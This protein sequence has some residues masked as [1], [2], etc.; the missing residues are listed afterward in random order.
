MATAAPCPYR[1]TTSRL[2]IAGDIEQATA[3][4]SRAHTR[5]LNNGTIAQVQVE[6][7]A[8][9]AILNDVAAALEREAVV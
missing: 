7:T 5:L 1:R 2:D 9:R 4:V 6:V 3:A 8:A